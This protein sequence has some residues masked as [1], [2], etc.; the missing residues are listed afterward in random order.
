MGNKLCACE[1]TTSQE[2]SA[3]T[4]GKNPTIVERM[5]LPQGSTLQKGWPPQTVD[6]SAYCAKKKVI[7]VGLP[8]AFTPT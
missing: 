1:D 4:Q 2:E 3:T 7:I 6:M 8:G 5:P